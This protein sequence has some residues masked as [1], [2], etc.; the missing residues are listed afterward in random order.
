[1]AVTYR[2]SFLQDE[3][4]QPG[5]LAGSIAV[6]AD[7]RVWFTVPVVGPDGGQGASVGFVDPATGDITRFPT[8]S[9][10]A[11]PAIPPGSVVITP[12]GGPWFLDAARSGFHEDGRDRDN[13]LGSIDPTTGAIAEYP[14]GGARSLIVGLAVGP[15]GNLWFTD[16]GA[17]SIGR[18]DPATRDLATFP[19]PEGAG[20][21]GPI[22][23]GPGGGLVFAT[24]LDGTTGSAIGSIDP[25]TLAIAIDPLPDATAIPLAIAAGPDGKLWFNER[26][27]SG[28]KIASF[29]PA[30]HLFA[31]FARADGD[32]GGGLTAG[33]DGGLWSAAGGS[34]L[35]FDPATH[36]LATYP[37]PAGAIVPEGGG[38]TIAAGPG[39]TL[40]FL[41]QG[42]IVSARIVAADEAVV[43][44]TVV[45]DP[46]RAGTTLN[47]ANGQLVYLDLDDDGA[48]DPG[49]PSS[50]TDPLGGYRFTGLASGTYT[51]RL[52]AYPG[53]V[54]TSPGAG[55]GRSVTAGLGQVATAAPIGI[56]RTGVTL[57]LA[58]LADPFGAGQPD[59][60][61]AE[62]VALYRIILGRDPE[63]EGRANAIAYLAGGGSVA[64]LSGDLLTSIEK[65][66]QV[67]ASFYRVFLGREPTPFERSSA[68][69]FL[70]RGGTTGDELAA[71]FLGSAEFSAG[72][73]TDAAFVDR[74]YRV[75]LGR[76]PEAKGRDS[77]VGLLGI[78][79]SRASVVA[80]FL[81]SNESNVRTFVG[82]QTLILGRPPSASDALAHFPDVRRS[83]WKIGSA[84]VLFDDPAFA[85]RAAA[86]VTPAIG[87][88]GPPAG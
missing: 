32:G 22:V 12:S 52:M 76:D 74:L 71:I 83:G 87:P 34:L 81:T 51:A 4:N 2:A 63:P 88:G 16:A 54:V 26:V 60:T 20:M 67:A 5:L 86:A 70:R 11:T 45:L 43:A 19:L 46:P 72:S 64:Q 66:D 59:V 73:A 61:T 50:R 55:G 17:G 62:V 80:G 77:W 9:G 44:G 36:D 56:A 1:M 3:P 18:F 84:T 53:T 47:P 40:S 25:V 58:Y 29:D 10:F 57:P 39:N 68:S 69:A 28:T 8:P 35:R 30:T 85:A 31:E 13:F 24:T 15:D 75:V 21:P 33:P 48:L 38:P 79:A 78:G 7:R 65:D 37:L 6:G 27:G 82:E 42:Y 49:E 14:I 41:A 23:A